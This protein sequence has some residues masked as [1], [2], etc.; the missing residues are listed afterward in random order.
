MFW[1][2]AKKALTMIFELRTVELNSLI[3]N[4]ESSFVHRYIVIYRGLLLA[5]QQRTDEAMS[6]FK[7]AVQLRPWF[8]QALLGLAASLMQLGQVVY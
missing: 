5:S 1:Y 3:N 7:R 8:A 2:H 6:S 4:I